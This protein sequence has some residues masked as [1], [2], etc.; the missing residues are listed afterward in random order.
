MELAAPPAVGNPEGVP[1][2]VGDPER[3]PDAVREDVRVAVC[4]TVA[5]KVK[6]LDIVAEPLAVGEG[7]AVMER[8][9]VP[10]KLIVPLRVGV[11]VCAVC[12][13]R[14]RFPLKRSATEVADPEA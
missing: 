11:D 7:D 12:S 3:V 13:L 9:R 6:H 10:D 5:E 8:E 14:A 4:V 1:E 2:G